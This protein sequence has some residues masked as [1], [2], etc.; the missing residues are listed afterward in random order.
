MLRVVQLD[1]VHQE[2]LGSVAFDDVPGN[3]HP[4]DVVVGAAAPVILGEHVRDEV[5]GLAAQAHGRGAFVELARLPDFRKEDI[6]RR[7]DRHRPAH[8]R[9]AQLGVTRGIEQC[10][11]SNVLVVPVPLF[12]RRFSVGGVKTT[13]ARMPCCEAAAVMSVVCEG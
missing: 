10:R 9:C 13:L 12:G 11:D 7:A 1:Q 6:H 4:V 3:V 5:G 2:H 8:G